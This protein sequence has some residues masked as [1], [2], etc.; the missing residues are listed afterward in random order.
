MSQPRPAAYSTIAELG[1]ASE[2]VAPDRP[3]GRCGAW[4]ILEPLCSKRQLRVRFTEMSCNF[5]AKDQPTNRESLSGRTIPPPADIDNEGALP[6]AQFATRRP[7]CRV[8]R[9]LAGVKNL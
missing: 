4:V 3:P 8:A 7:A 2:P 1:Y 9:S 5:K 6:Q